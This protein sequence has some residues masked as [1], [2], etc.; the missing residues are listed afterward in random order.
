MIGIDW[1]TTNLRAWAF[2]QSGTV[3]A[4]RTGGQGISA[5]ADGDFACVLRATIGD[6][7]DGSVPIALG[8]M[9]GSRQG[10]REAPYIACPAALETL[11]AAAVPI[12][13]GIGPGWIA[14][15]LSWVDDA[16]VPDVMRGEEC[17]LLGVD[18]AD[19]IV[20]LPGTHSKW[21]TI[22][23]GAIEEFRTF[24]TGELFSLLRTHSLLGRLMPETAPDREPDWAAFDRGAMRSLVDPAL[25]ALLFGV[26]TE[27]LFGRIPP[28]ALA[29]Y[30][31]GLLI[32]AEIASAP[33]TG[34][35]TIV[36]A[37]ALTSLYDRVLALAGRRGN[38]A[39]SGGDAAARGLWRIGSITLGEN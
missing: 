14:P 21:V 25:P 27:G 4:S 26:R 37:H 5:I 36:G 13:T 23:H 3:I 1:G 24:M 9:I 30:L 35:V 20:V 11:A 2:D 34:G 18:I 22:A 32:G 39:I 31:S 29:D 8:G 6:W 17:Q 15:G 10:W 7:T 38:R 33:G 19:G 16:G 12:D 28:P